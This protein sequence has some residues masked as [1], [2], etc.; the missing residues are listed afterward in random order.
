MNEA[1]PVR[2]VL[3][4]REFTEKLARWFT[5]QPG[6]QSVAISGE[7]SGMHPF[8]NGHLG[9]TLK[10]EQAVLECVAWSDT[11]RGLPEFENGT[12][13]IVTGSLRVRADRGGYQLIVESVELTGRGELFAL[14]ER[15][16]A[17]F[18]SEGLFEA[19]RKRAVPDLPRRVAL[20]SAR[21][22]AMQDFIE[23]IE[24]G[25]AFIAVDFIETRVQGLGAD[26]EIAAALDEASRRDVDAIVVTRGGGSYED[27]FPFNLE[28]VVRAIVRAKHPV[29]TAIG[30]SGDRHLA[31]DVADLT[32]GTP[33]LAAEHI[34][35]GWLLASRRLL[36]AR[37]DL[38]KAA[39]AAVG[40]AA[41][42]LDVAGK[43]LD[44]AGLRLSASK[45]AALAAR[46]QRLDRHN[47]QRVLADQRTRV[48]ALAGRLAAAAANVVPRRRQLLADRRGVLDRAIV[49]VASQ[50]DRRLERLQGRLDA[51]DPLAPLAHGYAIVTLGGK[52]VRD[53]RTL[54]PGAAIEARLERGTLAARVESVHDDD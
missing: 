38:E 53:A 2:R 20:I 51:R 14:H 33:S 5:R 30:H 34:T 37:R 24:R 45:R 26:V 46:T 21:G 8:G 11:C 23:T 48:V 44:S 3:S 9:F 16:K 43:N 29:I 6:I 22:K 32:F 18:R 15:L 49:N 36:V 1:L 54:A 13:T 27:L 52:V 7:V 50:L 17:K 19:A 4:V 47:P 39:R 40:H 41:Q 35:R 28:P 42:L 31:D 12:A 25:A 10:E